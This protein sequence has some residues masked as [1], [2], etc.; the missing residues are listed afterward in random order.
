MTMSTNELS[1]EITQEKDAAVHQLLESLQAELDFLRD[2]SIKDRMRLAKMG[3]RDV[4][5]VSRGYRHADG[6]PEFLP[7][8][9]PL[10]EFKKDVDLADWLRRLE[11]Q[12]EAFLDKVKDTALLAE[13]EAYKTARLY[14]NSVK[15]ASRAGNTGAEPIA[16]DLAI[17]Y[18]R[19][20]NPEEETPPGP[21]P[22]DPPGPGAAAP[23]R[24]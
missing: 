10:E 12:L 9:V 18:K 8:Y 15:A 11:K 7:S 24:G 20:N 17:H 2:L 14:Y 3:R 6:N 13:S 5:F 23:G 1:V 16:R 4:D 22:V 19:R 21:G